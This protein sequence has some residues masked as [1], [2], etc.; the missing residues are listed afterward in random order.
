MF[1]CVVRVGAVAEQYGGGFA[2]DQFSSISINGQSTISG[3]TAVSVRSSS[4]RLSPPGPN[5]YLLKYMTCTCTRVHICHMLCLAC[6]LVCVRVEQDGGG[7]YARSSHV[8]ISE[9]TTLSRNLAREGGGVWFDG[10]ADYQSYEVSQHDQATI[11]YVQ[12]LHIDGATFEANVARIRGQALQASGFVKRDSLLSNYTLRLH[13]NMASTLSIGPPGLTFR[14]PLGQWMPT[15]GATTFSTLVPGDCAHSCPLSTYG[16]RHDLTSA[17]QCVACPFGHYCDMPGLAIH[18]ARPCPVGTHLPVEGGRSPGACARCS[19]GSFSA[20]PANGNESCMPCPAG[21]LSEEAGAGSCSAC[22]DGGFCPLL[23]ASSARQTFQACPTGT[24]NPITG[25]SSIDSCIECPRGTANPIPG[26]SNS[27]VCKACLPGSFAESTGQATCNVCEA[28]SFQAASN[29]TACIACKPGNYCPEG[30]VAPIACSPG[31]YSSKKNLATPEECDVCQSGYWCSGGSQIPCLEGFFNSATGSTNETACERC[32]PRSTTV[33]VASTSRDSCVCDPGLYLDTI[34]RACVPCQFGTTCPGVGTTVATL[35]IMPGY[36]RLS[37]ASADV[38]RCP[39]ASANCSDAPECHQTTSG[40]RST[41]TA[42]SDGCQESLTGVYCRICSRQPDGLRVYYSA[43]SGQQVAQCKGCYDSARDTILIAFGV[44]VASVIAVLI[45]VLIYRSCL[46]DC[47]GE[48]HQKQL[49]DAWRKFTPHVKLKILISFYV[50]ATKIDIVYEVVLPPEVK[51]ILSVFA[52]IVSFG[53]TGVNSVLECLDMRGYVPTLTFYMVAPAAVALLVLL[54]GW[55]RIRCCTRSA[56]TPTAL[57]E[58]AAP[59]LLQLLF[60]V[61]PQVTTIAFDAF[62]CYPFTDSQ[63]LKADVSIQ[64]FTPQHNF[65]KALAWVAITI[66]P[67]G[68]LMLNATLLFLAREAIT[69]QRPTK[70]SRCIGFLHNEYELYF[71]WWEIIE[72]LRR[73]VLVG[74]MVLAQ[75]SMMQLILGILTSAAFMLFQVQASPYKELTDDLLA[76]SATFTLVVMFTCATAF[77]YAELTGLEGLWPILTHE[78]RQLY[79]P[80]D[81]ILTLFMLACSLGALILS[82]L[83]FLVQLSAEGARLRREARVSKARRLRWLKNDKEV[84]LATVQEGFYHIFLSQCVRCSCRRD[85]LPTLDMRCS[86]CQRLLC[87]PLS[88]VCGVQGKIRC[89]LCASD[90]L[91]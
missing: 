35:T 64:C 39:D 65:A 50:I 16:D 55:A 88:T 63:W 53:F 18:D 75:G 46:A 49:S 42:T 20:H 38:R 11:D 26:S 24:Y 80:N 87:P 32:P 72:M 4:R 54:V 57:L 52:L 41:G 51:R 43:A 70:L 45:I 34:S 69:T 86:L 59:Y 30:S 91:R 17:D 25:A 67:L 9:Q 36:Y 77:K 81:A 44:I 84:E 8:R 47:L 58:W 74:M 15:T 29:A 13:S 31:S 3:N 5:P 2:A 33:G 66:Y 27:T 7:I 78:Q 28:G 56:T 19:P 68:L 85:C 48:H 14:C 22:P 12:I 89:A 83:I 71:F 79:I 21:S 61:Y 82:A 1:V 60:L 37:N 90:C 6:G 76:S 10:T 73:F 40:C 23:G 62:S